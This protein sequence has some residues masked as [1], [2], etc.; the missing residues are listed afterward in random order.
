MITG[1]W[2]GVEPFEAQYVV[3]M[4]DASNDARVLPNDLGTINS[5]VPCFGAPPAPPCTPRYDINGDGRVLP[6]D[7]GAANAFVT[8]F[9]VP[10]PAGH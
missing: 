6:N 1:A 5:E 10:K 3:Q 7:L 9:P 2:V 8:S 4:G